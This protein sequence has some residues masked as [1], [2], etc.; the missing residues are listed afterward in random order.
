MKTVDLTIPLLDIEIINAVV[1]LNEDEIDDTLDG[2]LEDYGLSESNFKNNW[3]YNTEKFEFEGKEYII[4]LELVTEGMY[5][6]S[7]LFEVIKG[8]QCEVTY[9]EPEYESILGEFFFELDGENVITLSV[10][11]E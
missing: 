9:T 4:L 11:T 3:T 7:V 2:E 10:T 8:S 5:I 6:Q 1:G